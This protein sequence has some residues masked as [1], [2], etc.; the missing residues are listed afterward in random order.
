MKIEIYIPDELIELVK[1]GLQAD[2][3]ASWKPWQ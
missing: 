1:A 3:Q 2:R